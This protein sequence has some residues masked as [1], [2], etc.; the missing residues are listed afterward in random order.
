MIAENFCSLIYKYQRTKGLAW[1][2]QRIKLL[3]LVVTRYL[4]GQPLLVVDQILGLD[5]DGFPKSISFM[6][7]LIDSGKAPSISFCLTCLSISRAFS[8]DG[9]IDYKSITDPFKGDPQ[10]IIEDSFLKRFCNDFN[11]W[12]HKEHWSRKAF[13][14]TSKAGAQS[15]HALKSALYDI[16]HYNGGHLMAF[17][18]LSSSFT[19]WMTDV[20]KYI[21]KT[22]IPES[23]YGT[24]LRR[25]SIVKDPEQKMRV[26]AIFDYFTQTILELLSKQ[27]FNL[28]R[29]NFS[30]DRTFTQSPKLPYPLK[31]GEMY[32]SL[33]LKAATDRFPIDVQSQLLAIMIDCKNYAW[34]WKKTMVG[35]D[36]LTPDGNAIKYATG[37]PMGGRTSWS[38]FTISHHMVVQYAA[39]LHNQYPFKEYILLGDD[40]VIYNNIVAQEYLR[41]MDKLGVEI[42]PT[43]T[44]KSYT[45]YEFAKRT[46]HK[47]I[48]VSGVPINSIYSTIKNPVYLLGSI[49]NLYETGRSPW[50]LIR[51]IEVAR[52]LYSLETR[53]NKRLRYGFMLLDTFYAVFRYS[54]GSL[55]ELRNL[56]NKGLLENDLSLM[57]TDETMRA[58][59]ARVG[60]VSVNGILWDLNRKLIRF[61]QKLNGALPTILYQTSEEIAQYKSENPIINA[62]YNTVSP[63]AADI[64]KK[65]DPTDWNLMDLID[66][67]TLIDI[68]SLI[69]RE[70]KSRQVLFAMS[71]VGRRIFQEI[72]FDPCQVVP[73]PR[74]MQVQKA[75]K[76]LEFAIKKDLKRLTK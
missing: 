18:N 8:C 3:R 56:F 12:C 76:D 2:I 71:T 28:L 32:W 50:T 10:F 42:S 74:K 19:A 17:V 45:T 63:I 23:K 22:E 53:S 69:K 1:T 30:Q 29:N 20:R 66:T 38:M 47:G 73:R 65:L 4:T 60:S 64:M 9:P 6:K 7:K 5:K 59:F 62:I 11:L 46:F 13:Y 49:L 61:H 72:K 33:D 16:R 55:I 44:H 36:F 68:T 15:H 35:F 51:S 52:S 31:E 14:W 24:Y 21:F 75:F 40:I 27:L 41:I 70:R 39:F 43:K 34:A 48:E 25:L 26:I 58:E 57:S 37:Q 54:R 67:I